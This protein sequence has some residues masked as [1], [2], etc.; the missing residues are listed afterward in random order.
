MNIF[1]RI[2]CAVAVGAILAAV[3]MVAAELRVLTAR[4]NAIEDAEHYDMAVLEKTCWLAN[5]GS[6]SVKRPSPKK[7]SVIVPDEKAHITYMGWLAIPDTSD[8][9]RIAPVVDLRAARKALKKAH[10]PTS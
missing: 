3:I 2:T 1:L 7:R 5:P 8:L 6:P 10:S 9:P 4:L